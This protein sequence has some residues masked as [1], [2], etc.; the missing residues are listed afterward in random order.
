MEPGRHENTKSNWSF[1]ALRVFVASCFMLL[2]VGFAATA[3]TTKSSDQIVSWFTDLANRDASVREQARIAL[4]GIS[5][6]DLAQ[7]RTLVEKTR[8]LAPSQAMV[9]R[10]IVQQVYQATEPY[11]AV[12]GRPGVL[13]LP[14]P[15]R[16]I[17]IDG[18]D[19]DSQGG[20]VVTERIPGFCAYRFLQDGDVIV[21]MT[22]VPEKPIRTSNDLTELVKQFKGGETVHFQVIR[23]GRQ[24][25]VAVILSA[26][27]N[28]APTPINIVVQG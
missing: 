8:P 20:G 19:E 9:L 16:A 12:E 22:E 26:R 10:E 2:S 4:M 28:W 15:P 1:T 27:P 21:G 23:A 13:G 5:R 14:L 17:A 6:D 24:Q 25:D 3:P 18:S 11:E 7:L